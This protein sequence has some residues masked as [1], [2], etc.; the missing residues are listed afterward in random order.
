VQP[1]IETDH[2]VVDS[3]F[4]VSATPGV[5]GG[6]ND[7]LRGHG[8]FD[9]EFLVGQEMQLSPGPRMMMPQDVPSFDCDCAKGL[10]GLSKR[11]ILS[12]GGHESVEWDAFPERTVPLANTRW[13]TAKA[14]DLDES[15]Q[16]GGYWEIGLLLDK[17]KTGAEEVSFPAVLI[18]RF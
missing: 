7:E 3:S 18:R 15:A 6:F 13:F 17:K 16:M 2:Y 1:K 8:K 11:A 12:R 5:T 9:S 10:V 14:R 4:R